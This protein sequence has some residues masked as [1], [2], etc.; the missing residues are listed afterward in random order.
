MNSRFLSRSLLAGL[1][2]A[3][4]C[5]QSATTSHRD[6][7]ASASPEDT[8]RMITGSHVPQPTDRPTFDNVSANIPV[9]SA[10]RRPDS[11]VPSEPTVGARGQSDYR[12]REPSTG[13]GPEGEPTVGTGPD[14]STPKATPRPTPKAKPKASPT[15]TPN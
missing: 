13:A 7:T 1:L 14:N 15:P 9:G 8:R 5:T 3:A 2:V 10:S 11:L 6:R 12:L 4:G